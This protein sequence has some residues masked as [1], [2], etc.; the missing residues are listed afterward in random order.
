MFGVLVLG[1]ACTR[2]KRKHRDRDRLL[3][4]AAGVAAILPNCAVYTD[5]IRFSRGGDGGGCIQIVSLPEQ[6]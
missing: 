4:I 5:L 1:R 3:T 6:I 2:E